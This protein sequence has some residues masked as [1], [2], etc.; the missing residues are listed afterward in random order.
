MGEPNSGTSSVHLWAITMRS[1][2][3]N[4]KARR[5][6]EHRS[7]WAWSWCWSDPWSTWLAR[8][9]D[10]VTTIDHMRLNAR[11]LVHTDG[12]VIVEVAL[13]HGTVL[14]GDLA[15]QGGSQSIDDAGLKLCR[16]AIRRDRLPCI[17]HGNNSIYRHFAFDHSHLYDLRYQ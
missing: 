12:P 10:R 8:T 13:H 9:T 4:E 7:M 5:H 6:G 3:S 16:D 17:D 2:S 15:M 1:S 14:N 11:R